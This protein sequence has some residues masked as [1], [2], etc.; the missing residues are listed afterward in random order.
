MPGTLH[1]LQRLWLIGANWLPR[2]PEAA[3]RVTAPPT[4]R[5]VVAGETHQRARRAARC[6]TPEATPS[7]RDVL[8]L[9]GVLLG[10]ALHV[11]DATMP[12]EDVQELLDVRLWSGNGAPVPAVG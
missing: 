4:R 12:H 6:S 3:V 5:S 10:V 1:V 7:V 11:H 8:V 9:P 2:T